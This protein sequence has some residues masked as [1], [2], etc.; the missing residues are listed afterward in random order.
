[1]ALASNPVS[2][3]IPADPSTLEPH[4]VSDVTG[5]NIASNINEGLVK[6]DGEGKLVPALAKKFD[7]SKDG[8]KYTFH[9][10]PNLKWSD[11]KEMVAA[12]FIRGIELAIDPN[13][14]A[15]D[16]N[17]LWDIK[18]SDGKRPK[19]SATKNTVT[20]ELPEFHP[21]FIYALAMPLAAPVRADFLEKSKY[22]WKKSLPSSGPYF[23]TE[24]KVDSQV[25]LAIN[26]HHHQ[27]GK[28]EILFKVVAEETTAAN[29]FEINKLSVVQSISPLEISRFEKNLKKF[30]SASS[31]FLAVNMKKEMGRH[32]N[33]RH[34]ISQ[35]INREA[36]A[37]ILPHT[38]RASESFLPKSIPGAA[39]M[40]AGSQ[41]LK[42][43]ET[44]KFLIEKKTISLT[45]AS[46]ATSNL[47]MERIQNELS[48][49]IGI[50]VSLDPLEWKSFLAKVNSGE[51]E[52]FY[53][54]YSA[55][56]PEP[57]SH[58][59]LLLSGGPENRI[60]Y[61]NKSF[62]QKVIQYARTPQNN[63]RAKYAKEAHEMILKD[64]P[65]IP[66]LERD[67]VFLIDPALTGFRVNPF[68]IMTLSEI[69]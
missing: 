19:L 32:P 18:S 53:M 5:Y 62:D 31:F 3:Q 38:L 51:A 52:L 41:I 63:L 67:Q 36:L 30:P 33:W 46:S 15:R 49:K 44:E 37:K 9:L 45:Y 42:K 48:K 61:S 26:P 2:I 13:H 40:L 8:K 58:F 65:V 47:V 4:L 1:M 68:G 54:G 55:P 66:L 29:L 64:L 39:S 34:A 23:L 10:R 43:E 57:F 20:V 6:L 56:F 11:G 24:W 27:P 16:A 25:K 28:R 22:T 17:L 12:D 50:K 7:V 60:Q 35:S 21:S 69:N 14:M 59:K